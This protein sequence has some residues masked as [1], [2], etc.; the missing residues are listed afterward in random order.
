MT[1]VKVGQGINFFEG[2][3]KDKP[4]LRFHSGRAIPKAQY[5]GHKGAEELSSR[6]EKYIIVRSWER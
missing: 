4:V 6:S 3:I 5:L 1:L 2:K